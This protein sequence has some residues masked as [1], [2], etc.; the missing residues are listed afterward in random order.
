MASFQSSGFLIHLLVEIPA[1]INFLLFP[2]A[3]LSIP[4]PN[5]HAIIRQYATLLISTNLVAAAFAFREPDKLSGKI[6]G[7]LSVYHVAPLIR[8]YSR[9][10]HRGISNGADKETLREPLIHLVAHLICIVALWQ[11]FWQTYLYGLESI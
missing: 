10:H 2:N 9:L 1:S 5:A 7:A 11:T 6:A 3:Q 8:A 4:Q